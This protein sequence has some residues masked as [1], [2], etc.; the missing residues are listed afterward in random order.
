V[1]TLALNRGKRSDDL[2]THHVVS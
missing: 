2:L 1:L